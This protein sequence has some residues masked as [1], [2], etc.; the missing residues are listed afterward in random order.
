V[1]LIALVVTIR[2]ALVTLK[3]LL[4]LTPRQGRR[5]VVFQLL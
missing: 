4:L 5:L 1:E 3:V 2:R